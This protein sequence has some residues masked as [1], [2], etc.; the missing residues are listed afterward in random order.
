M[1]SFCVAIDW[2]TSH[3]RLW[4]LAEDG[5]I[6]AERR[7]DEGLA[8]SRAAGFG[9]IVEA[10]LGALNISTEMPIIICGMAGS[11]QGWQEAPYFEVPADLDQLP[12]KSIKVTD[13]KRDIRILPGIAQR[14]PDLPDVMRGEETQLLGLIDAGYNSG[15]VCL[16]G[17]HSKW[18]AMESG[19][20]E[21]FS[22][23]MSGELFALLSQ[24]ST[25]RL[26]QDHA[27][28]V[29]PEAPSF[30][31]AVL[32]AIE[33]PQEISN[34]L[35]SVRSSQLLGLASSESAAAKLS[36]YVIGLEIAGAISLHGPI[37][38]VHLVA[39]GQLSKLY[40]S[41]MITAGITVRRY[42]ADDAVRN[43]LLNAAHSLWGSN[44]ER[45]KYD[46]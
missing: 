46:A 10:H 44:L 14:N 3:F 19:R 4:V 8:H 12:R 23:F 18:V 5:S 45:V 24:Q 21:S 30:A 36:G 34:R 43:G 31:A 7:S 22:T 35:F 37:D 13:S 40:E 28:T 41:T 38:K 1:S 42:N 2:G 9:R 16:P 39:A 33:R 6:V 29:S 17:T 20:V 11:R 32:A 15:L 25:L 26:G 27:A